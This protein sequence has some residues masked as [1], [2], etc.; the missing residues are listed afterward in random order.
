MDEGFLEPPRWKYK[1]VKKQ[2]KKADKPYKVKEK[3]EEKWK[4][5]FLF[6]EKKKQNFLF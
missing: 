1:D 4:S 2:E 6:K 3:Q 5:F